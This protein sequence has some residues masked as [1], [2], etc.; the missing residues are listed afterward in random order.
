M[1]PTHE[2]PQ[3]LRE[4]AGIFMQRSMR[5]FVQFSRDSGL[6]MSQMSTLFRLY[7]SKVCGV[8]E[9]GDHLGVT[10]AAASQMVDRLVQLGIVERSEDP[11]DRRVR[12][13]TLTAKGKAIVEE[14]IEARHHW[15]AQLTEALT[16]DE[17]RAIVA[18]LTILT[19][20]AL[21]LEPPPQPETKHPDK[22]RLIGEPQ[23]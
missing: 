9:V 5:D 22:N 7:H 3:V 10:N 6:S 19:Q 23:G 2:F 16:P 1:D 4:W 20:A 14:S 18:A 12:Q 8:S 11:Q 17:Q 13:L 15:M 21:K